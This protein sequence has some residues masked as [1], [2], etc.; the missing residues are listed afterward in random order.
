ML[1]SLSALCQKGAEWIVSG[2]QYYKIKTYQ[3]GI[4]AVPF[5]QLQTAGINTGDL[6]NL[7]MWFRGQ[8]Q[9]VYLNNDTLFFYGKRNDGTLDSLL[10]GTG[11][12]A[13]TYYSIL[14]DT[15]AYFLTMGAA[16]GKRMLSSAVPTGTTASTWYYEQYLN[17]Y[18][19]RYYRG[20][21]Y[22]QETVKCEYDQ[23]E[24]WFGAPIETNGSPVA[25][26][27]SIALTNVNPD[28]AAVVRIE[29]QVVGGFPAT[30]RNVKLLIG[31]PSSPDFTFAFSP[32][33]NYDYGKVSV[34]I[35]ASYLQNN[36]SLN[37]NIQVFNST[38]DFIAPA[39]IKVL[40]P[41]NYTLI[42]AV[43]QTTFLDNAEAA[44][45]K[46]QISNI[47]SPVFI[48]NNT[49]LLNQE[50][51]P[52]SISNSKAVLNV[53]STVKQLFI[54]NTA[55]NKV[56]AI[57]P[58]DL[59]IPAF[60]NVFNIIYPEVFASS[61]QQ[62]VAYRSS[63]NGGNYSA[64]KCSF[65][66]LCNVF[67]Y[68][69]WTPLA[70]KRYCDEIILAN[71]DEKYLLILGKG[72]VPSLGAFIS[73]QGNSFYY[74][75]NP[76]AF[77]NSTDYKT[78]LVSFIPT[79]GEPGSDLM[80][81]IDANHAAQIHTGR[82]PAR[83]AVE[84]DEYLE[85]VRMHESLDSN[86]I[87][88]KKAVHLSGGETS[89]QI[90][91][92][93]KYID[94]Y[95][96][97][98]QAPYFGGRVIKTY[99]K[100]LQN[101]AI[102]DQLI[103]GVSTDINNGISL[104]TLF[105]HSSAEISDIDIGFVSN[106]VY[107]YKNTGK[108]PI[109]LMNGCTSADIFSSYSF[110]EDWINTPKL[111]AIDVLG[112]TDIGYTN[113]L[114]QFS[115]YFYT[116]QFNDERYRN[117]P[118]GFI[119]RKVID[120]MNSVNV[121]TDITSQ[122]QITQM[123]LS[124]DPAL[125]MYSPS[126]PDYAIYGDNQTAERVCSLVP[127]NGTTIKSKDPFTISIPIDNYGSTTNKTVEVIVKRYVNNVLV[128]TYQANVVP[129]SYKDSITISVSNNESDFSGNNRFEIQVDPSDSLKEI[130]KDNNIAYL[131][132]FMPASA[133]KCLFPLNYSVVST[134]PVTLFAQPN[135]LLIAETEYYFEIDT[136]KKFTS[137][138]K[139]S[140]IV[141]SGSL[142]F[143]SP[144]LL[145]NV[146]PSD[147]IVY[148]WRVRFNTIASGEDTLW[149][150]S[151]FIYIKNSNAGWS[152]TT[153]DQ[154]Q[155]NT[156]TGLKY[157]KN[158]LRWEFPATSITLK[159]RSIGGRSAGEPD[160]TLLSLNNLPILQSS[161][162]YNCVAN[163]GFFLLVLDRSSLEPKTYQP[164]SEGW[165]YCGQNFDTRYVQEISYPAN[166]NTSPSI[167]WLYGRDAD[168]LIK[169]IQNTN[170][171][172]YIII[173]NDGN[174]F[175]DQWAQV[176]TDYMRDSLHASGI[177]NLTS[178]QQPFLLVTR[179]NETT[180]ISEKI[181]L[182][183]ATDS[184]VAIDTV[185]TGFYDKGSIMTGLIGPS[186]K[187]GKMY[188]GIDSSANDITSVQ[189][190]RYSVSG[191]ILDTVFVPKTDS[192]DLNGTYLTDGVHAYCK[193]LL[194]MK[195]DVSLTPAA[196][197]KWQ[198]IYSGVP[199]GTL[200]PY[201]IGLDKY[202]VQT[203]SEGDTIS[204][205][206]RFDNISNLNFNQPI[207]VVYSIRN[208]S[209]ALKIDT[210]VYTAL[211]ANQNLLFTYKVPTKGWVGKNSLQVYVNPQIQP[212]Q[213]YSNNVLETTFFVEADKTQPILEVAFDGVRIFDGDLVSASPL[214]S[215]S[216]RD[217]NKY[218]LMTDPSSIKLFLQY[219]GQTVPVQ[220]TSTNPIVQSWSLQQSKT[221]TFVA[222]IKPVGLPDGTYILSV[223]GQDATGNKAGNNTYKITFKVEN[224]PTISYFYPYP[225]PFSTSTRFVFTLSGTT[226]PSD[227][228]IQI[229]TVS[230]IVVKEIFKEELGPIHIGNNISEY[231]WNGTDQ[232]GDRLANGVYLYRVI[233]KDDT[234][235]FEHRENAG[236]KAF[237][238]DW[239][240]LYIL[241]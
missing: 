16:P 131:N 153:I 69:E 67:S 238:H 223:Q 75:K 18:T 113:Y 115:T 204:M 215:I 174:S 157:N 5:S 108:Y 172:D 39:Y 17:V 240:K 89:Q 19:D 181:N 203:R 217:N 161:T 27:F 42:N 38:Y 99:V 87:W 169:A 78:K 70:I 212:E 216:L 192:L 114:N 35:P 105:G 53:A 117:K 10:Y 239:G 194:N 137:P 150:N 62:Y 176:L 146:L 132:Y 41:R 1:V 80:F 138:F 185:L 32:F 90:T 141:T 218:L 9:A 97:Y 189:L 120:S 49:D 119:Q 31:N 20:T 55:F 180:P 123:N 104:L 100:N 211:A 195:D 127:D 144:Q 202:A 158:T 96:A 184:Y 101:G 110:A 26:N 64:G 118:I 209:G 139:Q 68:G 45:K 79:F 182:S 43:N 6:T 232:Y 36:S 179:R 77:W 227:L 166:T 94:T 74:R 40:Y 50:I 93:K 111:G 236:D 34:Q 188:L 109:L 133:V 112:H 219:P 229:M 25:R 102:D 7:Q 23:G 214:I 208:E 72:T 152:Q 121:A 207:K 65:E 22:S 126:K 15:C 241:R 151:S 225:N 230:G 98:Y 213:Y 186:S 134:Q 201:V 88:R 54:Q 21:Y 51:V 56:A 173:L 235:I 103:S 8:Q 81:S 233:I 124:G 183:T 190:I 155:E 63:A 28:P 46:I 59:S 135:I 122:A 193:L 154:F 148:F 13:H 82:V 33:N 200:N 163:G 228:K 162:Y 107:G 125:R 196:L 73:N 3:E 147:S 170:K 205:T 210:V 86:L 24:G 83:T 29:V 167:S 37:C 30:G 57:S 2:Q 234:Q 142:P 221:N 66:K 106:P 95:K 60:T 12:Q 130:R 129:V 191:T 168:G 145:S 76:S 231:A 149:D 206:Y 44:D 84:I 156:L 14:S 237:K 197:T 164:N 175:K 171:N 226:V 178:G 177:A 92:F 199:E 220:I 47:T 116:F 4:Y 136:S 48:I 91:L 165:Y 187:W 140:K 143:W 128:K 71:P 85:K 11:L 222:E 159:A 198:I 52:Y 160:E 58:V 61:A 224:K